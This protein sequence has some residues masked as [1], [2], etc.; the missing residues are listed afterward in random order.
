MYKSKQFQQNNNS[1][2]NNQFLIIEFLKLLGLVHVEHIDRA[3]PERVAGRS[4]RA[5]PHSHS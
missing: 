5:M 4:G 1:K 3:M 2:Q